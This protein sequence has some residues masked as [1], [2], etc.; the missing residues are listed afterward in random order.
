MTVLS[1]HIFAKNTDFFQVLVEVVAEGR[2]PVA[3]DEDACFLSVGDVCED[4]FEVVSV[5]AGEG[6]EEVVEVRVGDVYAEDELHFT[7]FPVVQD[8]G[9]GDGCEVVLTE[10]DSFEDILCSDF[11]HLAVRKVSLNT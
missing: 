2:V 4:Q 7:G 1:G 5:D 8:A 6:E 11:Q 9:F 3:V 10:F